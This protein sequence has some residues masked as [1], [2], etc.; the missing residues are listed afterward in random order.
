MFKIGDKVICISEVWDKQIG[1]ENSPTPKEGKI[2]IITWLGTELNGDFLSVKG[3][4]QDECY[5]ISGFRKVDE[6]YSELIL[7]NIL[8]QIKERK[9]ELA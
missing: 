4:P 7:E 2:Y 5:H 8:E 6:T 3:M 1:C 9:P